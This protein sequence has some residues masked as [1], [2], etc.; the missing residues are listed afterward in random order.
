MLPVAVEKKRWREESGIQGISTY[1][2]F[3]IS[4]VTMFLFVFIVRR[5]WKDNTHALVE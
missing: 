3:F 2:K 1:S 5:N 4:S